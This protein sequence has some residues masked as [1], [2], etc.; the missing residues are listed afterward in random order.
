MNEQVESYGFSTL[1]LMAYVG[2]V[3]NVQELKM[4]TKMI[5]AIAMIDSF[6]FMC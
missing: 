6:A 3:R 1:A 5:S 4:R 2:Q